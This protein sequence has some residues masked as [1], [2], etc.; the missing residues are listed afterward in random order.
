MLDRAKKRPLRGLL[1]YLA[2]SFLEKDLESSHGTAYRA[3]WNLCLTS[4][5]NLPEYCM[6]LVFKSWGKNIY[7]ITCILYIYCE[8]TIHLYHQLM[9]ITWTYHDPHGSIGCF[10][11]VPSASPTMQLGG[12]EDSTR[13]AKQGFASQGWWIGIPEIIS[14]GDSKFTLVAEPWAAAGGIRVTNL[15]LGHLRRGLGQSNKVP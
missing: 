11:H 14:Q 13:P 1:T 9:S 3:S 10:Q 4:F 2:S 12:R 5:R 8:C 15:I 6:K 7:I